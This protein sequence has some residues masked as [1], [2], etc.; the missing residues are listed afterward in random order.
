M[1]DEDLLRRDLIR[2]LPPDPKRVTDALGLARRDV[3]TSREMLSVN[4]DWSY[5]IAYNAM[6]QAVRALMFFHGYRPAG[7]NQHIAV[8]KYAEVHL[9]KQ[10]SVP[11]DRMRRKRHAT[12]YDIA[13]TIP[14]S[15]AKNAV[16]RAEELYEVILGMVQDG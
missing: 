10:W 6:L 5:T 15:E 16:V 9:G 11:L 2:P 13:G 12:V 7:S 14:E 4:S 8:V 1:I 3:G